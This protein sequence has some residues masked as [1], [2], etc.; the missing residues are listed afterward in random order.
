[1]KNNNAGVGRTRGTDKSERAAAVCDE[2][3]SSLQV[4]RRERAASYYPLAGGE[5]GAFFGQRFCFRVRDVRAGFRESFED[6]VGGAKTVVRLEAANVIQ[7]QVVLGAIGALPQMRNKSGKLF[8]RIIAV[9]LQ[10][11]I[12][13]QQVLDLCAIKFSVGSLK[14]SFEGLYK[15]FRVQRS[16]SLGIYTFTPR[17]A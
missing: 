13:R 4:R 7:P 5:F 3:L 11:D 16:C 1:M 9:E 12:M 10:F 15:W 6:F 17:R 14:D 8:G 2:I